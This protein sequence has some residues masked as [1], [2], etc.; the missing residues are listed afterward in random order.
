[1]TAKRDV[2]GRRPEKKF[3]TTL[4]SEEESTLSKLV[5]KTGGFSACMGCGGTDLSIACN[6]P[7]MYSCRECSYLGAPIIF[8]DLGAYK[9]FFRNKRLKH[10]M[11]VDQEEANT[12]LAKP[13]PG[14]GKKN[15]VLALTASLV[16]PGAGQVYLGEQ[17]KAWA[18]L[19]LAFIAYVSMSVLVIGRN[20]LSENIMW[21][22]NTPFLILYIIIIYASMDA[23]FS[24]SRNRVEAR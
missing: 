22:L 16:L 9:K 24:A 12:F 19:V 13:Y 2:T 1:M 6:T 15:P 21:L 7:R 4:S 23:Y 18:I 3:S 5:E 10:N 11:G 14:T 20:L 8:K 17:R